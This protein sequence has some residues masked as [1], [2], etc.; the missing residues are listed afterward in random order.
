M[1][2][3]VLN[4]RTAEDTYLAV[5][6][7]MA[8]NRPPD[9]LIVVD[10]DVADECRA[11]F[12]GPGAQSLEP[13]AQYPESPVPSPELTYLHTGRNLGF[14]GGMNVGA[15]AALEAGADLVLLANS[16]IVVSPALSR[17]ARVDAEQPHG[18]R[19]SGSAGTVS[20]APRS[21][22]VGRYQ[23]QPP[24]RS[25]ARAGCGNESN[26]SVTGIAQAWTPSAAA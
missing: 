25:H 4:H 6:S 20:R 21:R 5:S 14:S 11:H 23:L 9:H 10:N 1:A 26:R 15:R 7:L 22:G 8:S 18:R 13:R 16:D 2:V 12:V 19:Y 24:I 17:A 3:V